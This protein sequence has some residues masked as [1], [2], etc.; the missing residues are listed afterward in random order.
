MAADKENQASNILVRNEDEDQDVSY[1]Q[2]AQEVFSSLFF[3]II[4]EVE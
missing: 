2:A 3:V 4:R 1:S